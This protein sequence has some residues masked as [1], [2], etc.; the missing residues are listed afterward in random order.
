MD[1][2]ESRS[3]DYKEF[4]KGIDGFGLN[5]EEP[6]L[7]EAFAI[8]DT[9]SSGCIDFDEFLRA[10]R[11][12]IAFLNRPFSHCFWVCVYWSRDLLFLDNRRDFT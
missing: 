7:K 5:L 9:D 2:D 1:D 12:R 6:T 11:V 3:L 4:K 8:L 10:L